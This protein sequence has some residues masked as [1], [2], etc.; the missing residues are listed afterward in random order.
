MCHGQLDEAQVQCAA[1]I[2]ADSILYALPFEKAGRLKNG[3]YLRRE[4][5]RHWDNVVNV[6]K[7]RVRQGNC[8]HPPDFV[9]LRIRRIPF[10][11]RIEQQNFAP[12]KREFKGGVSQPIDLHHSAR[13]D[14][15]W[16]R[17]GTR[18]PSPIFTSP[19]IE[20]GILPPIAIV[21]R[22][23]LAAATS[24]LCVVLNVVAYVLTSGNSRNRYGFPRAMRATGTGPWMSW[25]KKP[26]R[27]P[28]SDTLPRFA[29]TVTKA[30]A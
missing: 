19:G 6:V 22:M 23:A 12:S 30:A 26:F 27:P 16:G 7:M 29:A 24:E 15:K 25:F 3:N 21:P 5:F 18:S 14:A 4:L 8:V 10:Y 20:T 11:P 17:A 2:D 28:C 1:L 9:A 13:L